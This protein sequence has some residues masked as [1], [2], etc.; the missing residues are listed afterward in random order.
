MPSEQLDELFA[1]LIRQNL[2]NDR[3]FAEQQTE[4][5]INN[6]YGPIKIIDVLTQHDIELALAEQLAKQASGKSIAEQARAKKFGAFIPTDKKNQAAQSQFL[7]YR[8]FE[9]EYI[10]SLFN[11]NH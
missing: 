2:Q 9:E 10:T 3:R 4:R 5:L 8:G 1:Q 11:S 6:G 7:Y